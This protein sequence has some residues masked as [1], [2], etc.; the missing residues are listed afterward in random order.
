MYVAAITV[1]QTVVISV[2][3]D[4]LMRMERDC[5]DVYYSLIQQQQE[6]PAVWLR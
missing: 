2:Y 3:T 6:E 1:H 5:S 4:K